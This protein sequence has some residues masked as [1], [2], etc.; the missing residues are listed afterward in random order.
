MSAPKSEVRR[1]PRE[2][3]PRSLA[4]VLT[5]VGAEVS[6]ARGEP[7]REGVTVTGV[8]YDSRA[9]YPDDVYVALPGA[10]TH[11]ATFVAAA[12]ESGAVAVI[13]DSAGAELARD[14]S[15]PVLVVDDP[16]AHLGELAAEVYG[17]PASDLVMFGV[18]GTNGKTTTVYLLESGLR[19][20]GHTTGLIGTVETQIAGVASKSV[21]TTPESA[22]VHALLAVMREEGV[23]ACAMEVSSHA[24]TFGRVDG[25]VYDV[26]G[27]TNLTQ[28]HL[29]FHG[30]MDEYFAVKSSL[31]TQAHSR[32]G[33]VCVDDD[34]GSRLRTTADVPTVGVSSRSH[35]EPAA[36]QVL[37]ASTRLDGST[38]M[39]VNGPRDVSVKL[40]LALP[41]DFN[42]SNAA[43]AVAMLAEA[44]IDADVVAAGVAACQGV[45]GRM[46]RVQ[47]PDNADVPLAIVDY[48]HTPDAIE[49][50]LHA[51]PPRGRVISVVG[52]GG[53][54]D[55]EKRRLM[56][57]AA[58]H[59][60][61]VVVV[62]D[63]NPRSEEPSDIR[64]AVAAGARGAEGAEVIEVGD[65]RAAIARA[66]SLATGADTVV[67][68]GKGHEQ[69]QEIAGI[70]HPFDDAQTLLAEM[71]EW[72]KQE[73]VAGD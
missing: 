62:T 69:G 50:A 1:R 65:R 71:V 70:V 58:G 44:G 43:L 7:L 27:F 33:V 55:R 63:D 13:T 19:A 59:G 18:T 14:L 38:E 10:V 21:R 25:I 73:G 24:L 52:A 26:A 23:T 40:D 53:D 20:A 22:D 47:L 32:R 5:A 45:P 2:V 15:V 30:D 67:V 4:A 9:V 16:R 66:L 61:D 37:T 64:A 11:G 42:V 48:A 72:A 49:K 31:F 17:H 68:L 3:S 29:D 60:S 39:T 54:R 41:G 12:V 34:Y 36:W 28:D 46:Q 35:G 6:P 51:L 56:G 8:A 57:A